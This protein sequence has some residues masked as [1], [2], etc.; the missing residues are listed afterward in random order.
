MSVGE[1]GVLSATFGGTL[2]DI[3]GVESFVKVHAGGRTV[4]EPRPLVEKPHRI[5]VRCEDVESPALP[6]MQHRMISFP[7]STGAAKAKDLLE[8][9]LG[10]PDRAEWRLGRWSAS[11]E[12]CLEHPADLGAPLDAGF[13]FWLITRESRTLRASG[14]SVFPPSSERFF[15]ILL[16]GSAGSVAWTQIGQPFAFPVNWSDCFIREANRNLHTVEG[17]AALGLIENVAYS[18][19]Y[20]D[21]AGHYI[22]SSTLD[23]WGG[24]FVNNISGI[25]LELLVPIR[26]AA[27]SK[28][29][30]APS[31]PDARMGE[32]VLRLRAVSGDRSGEIVVGERAGARDRWDPF[33]HFVPPPPAREEALLVLRNP[34]G[35]PAPGDLRADVRAVAPEVLSWA[36]GL[37][38]EALVEVQLTAEAGENL[39]DDFEAFLL[40]PV[41]GSS[42]P[43]RGDFVQRVVPRPGERSREFRIVAGPPLALSAQGYEAL[44]PDA[45]FS[46]ERPYP[47]P[48]TR[49][50]TLRFAIPE[51]GP[52]RLRLF[53]IEGRLVRELANET[54]S[55]GEQ[56]VAWDG[57]DS[58]GREVG[59]GVYFFRLDYWG[60]TR[61][62]RVVVFR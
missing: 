16:Q 4:S 6:A 31:L 22:A 5:L 60:E 51:A 13:G 53:N 17:A 45:A 62:A 2:F 14:L 35:M 57:R 30:P 37:R 44:R 3:R 38:L 40:D 12:T 43:L 36:L 8:D 39:P 9:D 18:F 25:D 41:T 34:G 29:L 10:E 27:P 48:A 46:I 61:T 21:G 54:R 33:D 55:S 58:R 26:E 20:E 24:Y 52:V 42:T 28:G 32:W 19:V 49:G 15:P 1:G 47:N 50:T 7:L 23:P 11:A 56:I 59:P